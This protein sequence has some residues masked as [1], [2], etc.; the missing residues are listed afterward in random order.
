MS[1]KRYDRIEEDIRKSYPNSCILWIEEVVNPRLEEAYQKQ[2]IEIV[3][4]RG[5][6]CKELELYHG[7]REEYI[8][9]IVRDGFDPL[10]NKRSSYGRGSYFA[11]NASYSRDYAAPASDQ[12]SFMLICSV[13]VGEIAIYG[14]DKPID[15]SKHDNSV[16][17][18]K[19]PSIYVSPYEAGAIPRYVVA[20]HRYAT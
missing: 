17:N 3:K 7:T 9:A 11:K 10:A 18:L 19:S 15:I 5:K 6:P 20:F 2:R 14:A 12:V 16:D 13:L 8:N 1:D 4:K